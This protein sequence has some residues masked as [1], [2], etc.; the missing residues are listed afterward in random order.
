MT[1]TDGS[2]IPADGPKRVTK[3]LRFEVLNRDGHTCRYC[4]GR[5][6]DV[7]LTVD[8]VVPVALGG[9]NVPDN[10][11]AACKDCNAGKSSSHPDAPLVAQVADDALRWANAM[12]FAGEEW[13][14]GNVAARDAFAEAWNAQRGG[15]GVPHNWGMSI[16]NL[17]ASGLTVEDIPLIVARAFERDFVTDRWRWFCGCAWNAVRDRQERARGIL[18]SSPT[19]DGMEFDPDWFAAELCANA[20]AGGLVPLEVIGAT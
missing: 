4:G 15:A 19:G 12:R 1:T 13:R 2:P 6:P 10:L 20:F 3:R 17:V 14:A 8:H 11:V 16:D 18:V 5:A 9:A 7:E